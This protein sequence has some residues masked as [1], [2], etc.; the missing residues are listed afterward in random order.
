MTAKKITIL[1]SFSNS[2]QLLSQLAILCEKISNEEQ[3]I[4]NFPI[5]GAMERS[6]G[7]RVRKLSDVCLHN[8][9]IVARGIGY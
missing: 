3:I 1:L 8:N 2:T 5:D 9:A 6:G 7:G 4:T